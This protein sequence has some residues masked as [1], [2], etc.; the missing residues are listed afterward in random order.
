MNQ[1]EDMGSL[2]VLLTHAFFYKE[3]VTIITWVNDC[4]IFAREKDL[5][6]E[7]ITDLQKNFTL[8]EEGDV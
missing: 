6:D 2:R 8:T 4:L 5:A 3:G 1:K 7:L